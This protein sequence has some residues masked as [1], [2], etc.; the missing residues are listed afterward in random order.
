V[1]D[2]DDLSG[3]GEA[4]RTELAAFMET[5]DAQATRFVEQRTKKLARIAARAN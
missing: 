1:F 2:R 4:A 5:L 3:E